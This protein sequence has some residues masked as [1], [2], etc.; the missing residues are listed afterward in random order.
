[1]FS[2]IVQKIVQSR[3]KQTINMTKADIRFAESKASIE[4]NFIS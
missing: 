3:Y 4:V 2:R 1:M